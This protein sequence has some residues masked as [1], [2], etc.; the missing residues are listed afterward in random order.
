MQVVARGVGVWDRNEDS[1]P[2]IPMM[3]DTV[4][5]PPWGYFVLRFRADNPGVWVRFLPSLSYHSHSIPIS[6]CFAF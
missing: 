4:V 1:L 2:K 3:R 5:I 6:N